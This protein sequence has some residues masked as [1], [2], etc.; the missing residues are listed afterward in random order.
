MK[1]VTVQFSVDAALYMEAEAV[2]AR[3][4][5]TMEEAV[6]LFLRETVARGAIPFPYTEED[7]M[8]AKALTMEANN[9]LCNE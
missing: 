7:V 9:D 5:L 3:I 4:G 6:E 1:L 8:A 2:L